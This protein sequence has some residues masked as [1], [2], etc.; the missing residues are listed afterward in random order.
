MICPVESPFIVALRLPLTATIVVTPSRAPLL[1]RLTILPSA[2][3][4]WNLTRWSERMSA[5]RDE[6]QGE[7][8][9]H[10]KRQGYTTH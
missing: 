4:S 7:H 2:P 3:P 8:T 5:E 1:N 9:Q 6:P 10:N